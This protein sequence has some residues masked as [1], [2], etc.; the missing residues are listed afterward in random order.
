VPTKK[1]KAKK[2]KPSVLGTGAARKAAD[3]AVKRNKKIEDVAE[4]TK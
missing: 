2:P 3:A 1:D 4:Q